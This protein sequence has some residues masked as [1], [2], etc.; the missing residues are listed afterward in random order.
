MSIIAQSSILRSKLQKI[1]SKISHSEIYT[2]NYLFKSERIIFPGYQKYLK[3][4]SLLSLLSVCLIAFNEI[5]VFSTLVLSVLNI[6]FH[7][8]NKRYIRYFINPLVELSKVYAAANKL[9]QIGELTKAP[10]QIKNFEYINR[11]L[12]L[13]ISDALM[14]SDVGA[15][16]W[17]PIEVL[18]IVLLLEPTM[19]YQLANKL[20]L[21]RDILSSLIEYV[22]K[23]D[24]AYSVAS[25]RESL[26]QKG[27]KYC[28]QAEGEGGFNFK[29]IY[30]SLVEN[31]V[32][33]DLELGEKSMILTGS[34][35]SGK[36]TFIKAVGLN[37][38]SA[39]AINTC[40]AEYWHAPKCY[41]DSVLDVSD[42]ILS[43]ESYY[44]SETLRIKNILEKCAELGKLENEQMN[45]QLVL[46]DEIF[47]GT[48]TPERVAIARAVLS[49]LSSLKNVTVI[50]STHDIEL[51]HL[52]KEQLLSFHFSESIYDDDLHFEYKLLSGTEYTR[53]AISILKLCDY[54]AD[55]IAA[56]SA[57]VSGH[58][59]N[60]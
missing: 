56:S 16:I 8:R 49:Y 37:I 35:M 17:F 59:E 28:L 44:L 23:I 47:K 5:F 54:P 18:K 3:Y 6:F 58:A 21:Q 50:A 52:L 14:T 39:A 11:R 46:I 33:N 60:Q 42:N 32:A 27:L 25:L 31:C 4:L 13:F 9:S 55:I 7:Y 53:N 57:W 10:T 43:G 2:I 22:G 26:H 34:N 41:L 38:I 1:F 12:K 30:H 29:G 15:I 48:N 45:H 24:C 20:K 19:L 36:S 40:F 51:A